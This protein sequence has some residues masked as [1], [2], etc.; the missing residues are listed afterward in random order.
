[1]EGIPMQ[2]LLEDLGHALRVLRRGG[3]FT[4][5]AI[6]T[7]ALGIGVNT[8]IFSLVNAV[9]LRPLPVDALDRLV[10]IRQD[11]PEIDLFDAQL[12]PAEVQ[13]LAAG[14]GAFQA[15]TGFQVGDRTLT[16]QGEPARVAVASTLGDFAGVFG[17]LP[18]LGRFYGPDHS[19][20]G[21]REV[22]VI[23][24]GL[25]RQ[26][27]GEDPDFIGTLLELDGISYEV[28]GVMPG[29][30]R[31]PRQVQVWVPFAYTDR[32]QQPQMRGTLIMTTV[33]RLRPDV[34]RPQLDAG[35]QLEVRRWS[36]TYS[37]GAA[38]GKTLTSIGFVEYLA[39]PLRL[40]LLVLM[41]AVVFVLMIVA[42]NVTCLQLVR[43]AGRSKELAVRAALGASRARLARQL[44]IETVVLGLLGGAFGLWIGTLVLDLI[45]RWQPARQ[46]YLA[47]I[48]LDT[49]VL[50]FTAL[51]ALVAAA[52]SGMAPALRA[53]RVDPQDVLRDAPRGASASLAR[54]RVL[55]TGIVLQIALAL[56][57]VLGSAL[58]LRTLS[59]LLS[60]NPGFSP[61]NVTTAQVT[62]PGTSYGSPDRIAAFFDPLLERVRA[63]PG[64]DD[65]ALVWGLPLTNQGSSS[66]FE[67]IGRAPDPGEPAWHAEGRYASTGYFRTM[68]ITI[69]GR[70]FEDADRVGS[71]IVAII[72]R[73]FAEQFFPNEDPIG[74]QIRHFIGDRAT[75]VGI[76]DRVDHDEIGDAPK[77]V[78][79]YSLGHA[80]FMSWRT[81]VVRSTEPVGTVAA[82]IRAVVADL[83]PNVPIY[84]VQ[85]MEGLIEQ[86]LGPRRLALFALGGFAA[87]AL[88]LAALG[89][90]GVMRYTTAQRTRE[91]G[92]RM[93]VGAQGKDVVRMVIRQGMTMAALGVALGI[94][95]AL[96]LT[97]LMSGVL[98]G[99]SPHDPLAFI[100]ATTLLAAV[101]LLA[102]WVPAHRATRLD[103]IEVLRAE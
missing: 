14:A 51:A 61:V 88:T 79:Y 100:G 39:G 7:L 45:E 60:T 98:F 78:A 1:M 101:A 73:T 53:A 50:A 5:I 85:T 89:I 6:L 63:L 55:R 17:V 35:L 95:A 72:D 16:G 82:M 69:R 49:T 40:I 43:A 84:D 102:C 10:V 48:T 71:P 29:E 56:V 20:A 34:T 11:L 97:R 37:G 36:E 38:M 75:I 80:S 22:A 74:K 91:I 65:A 24:R 92:I 93:A 70:E 96:A 4:L 66:P 83:D 21:P 33:A 32:W 77:A 57:L 62:L 67:I 94:G 86:S 15:V 59:R 44:L 58:M 18:Q 25:W 2:R 87:L 90:Y 13:D 28:I 27:S 42:A 23:S 12:A 103:P 31:Y 76:A 68:G 52:A 30:L 9:L 46:M 47:D 41:G 81:I 26:L 99:V 3:A 8:A 54:Q 19:T 64:I